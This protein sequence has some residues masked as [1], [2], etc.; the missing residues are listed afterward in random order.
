[1]TDEEEYR[2]DPEDFDESGE[3]I[4]NDT[5]IDLAPLVI[6]GSLTGGILLFLANPFVDPISVADVDVAFRNVSA[7]VFAVGLFTGAGVYAGQGKTLLGAVHALGAFGWVSL[8]LGTILSNDW[9]LIGGGG[10]LM[11]GA[12]GLVG[13]TWRATR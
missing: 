1:V 11:T 3:L 13:L 6:V 8:A 7:F 9:L 2:F 12:A 10:L 4:E 5:D